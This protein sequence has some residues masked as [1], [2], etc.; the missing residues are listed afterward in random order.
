MSW[1]FDAVIA[2]AKRRYGK[3]VCIDMIGDA[4]EEDTFNDAVQMILM[5]SVMW[6]SPRGDPMDPDIWAKILPAK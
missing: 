6:D 2:E 4:L 3:A 1:D 5:D